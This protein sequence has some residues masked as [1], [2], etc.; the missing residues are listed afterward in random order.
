MS[1]TKPNETMINKLKLST[2]I[3]AFSPL[4]ALAGDEGSKV[5]FEKEDSVTDSSHGFEN[6]RHTI[7]NPTLFDLALPSTQVRAIYLN[8]QLPDAVNLVGGG[9]A[10]IGGEVNVYAVQFEYAFN[11]RLSLVA[12]KDGFIDINASQSLSDA[13]GLADL[14]AGLKYAFIL[15]SD[16]QF[17]LAGSA[18]VELPTGNDDVFQGNGDGA[19]GLGLSSLKLTNGWQFAGSLGVHLPFDQSGE[20]TTGHL[21]G[22]IGYNVTEKLYLLGE[23][24]W[25]RVISAGDGETQFDSQVSGAVPSAAAIQG[26]DLINL[27]SSNPERDII[28][29]AVGARYKLFDN[30]DIGVAYEIPLTDEEDALIDSRFTID[31]VYEF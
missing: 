24:N 11:E 2:A 23:V 13:N 10:P 6:V 9:Q 17:A 15:D 1:E 14:A 12:T 25:F 8:H 5:I 26:G 22:H 30:M 7:S 16:K 31:L 21:S 18:T 3:C 28:T 27:G 4:I 20:S 29:A 19:L